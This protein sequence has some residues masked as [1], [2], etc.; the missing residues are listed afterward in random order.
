[1]ASSFTLPEEAKIVSILEPAADAAG[2]TGDY[3]S[4]KGA[5]K[6]YLVAHINQGNAA[7]VALTPKQA[8]AVAGTG[9]KVITTSRIWVCDDAA[10]SDALVRQ[11]DAAN[12]TTSAG[13]TI[14]VV[15]FEVDP[16]SLDVAGGFDCLTLVTGASNAAN[17]TSAVAYL[18]PLRYPA[19]T[20]PSA[21]VD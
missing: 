8:S 15:V 16:S 13:L 4:L 3:I 1:M 6:V 10:T 18:T 14:K 2:R 12:Y 5:H 20:P 21:I 9:V 7:T 19:A 17:I 11:S